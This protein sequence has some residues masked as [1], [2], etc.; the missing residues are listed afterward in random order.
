M[1]HIRR[2]EDHALITKIEN[3]EDAEQYLE[4]LHTKKQEYSYYKHYV[5]A[6][7]YLLRHIIDIARV[8]H[9]ILF[10][11]EL[12]LI[13]RRASNMFTSTESYGIKNIPT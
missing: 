4:D 11:A 7:A 8:E 2:D 3:E 9:V 5:A 10:T 6:Q 12:K 1:W 13:S